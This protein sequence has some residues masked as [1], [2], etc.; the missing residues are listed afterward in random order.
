MVSL[1]PSKPVDQFAAQHTGTYPLNEITQ[2]VIQVGEQITEEIPLYVHA[3]RG[4]DAVA[5]VDGGL[6]QSAAAIDALLGEATRTAPL[7]YLCNTHPHHDHIGN[8]RRL[9]ERTGAIV[10]AAE[11]AR[12]WLADPERNIREFAF[13]HPHIFED[14]GKARAELA[15]TFD[16]VVTVDVL[17]Q[18]SVVLNLGGG[19]ELEAV[20][21]DGHLHAELAWFERSSRCLILGDAVTAIDW[22]IFHGH[23]DPVALRQTIRRLRHLVLDRDVVRIVFAHYE[24]RDRNGFLRLLI[25]LENYLDRVDAWVLDQT[26][27]QPRTLEEIW[28]GVCREARKEPE[29][30]SLA[31]VASHLGDQQLRGLVTLTA[32]ETYIRTNKMRGSDRE[33]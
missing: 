12:P 17:V 14:T 30:R 2:S 15:P 18:E 8:F 27:P 16:G 29:F 33:N 24:A 11:G 4:A 9:R 32:P 20:R 6:P 19:V 13:H 5:L 3:V 23:V 21:A 22:P 28:R 26:G 31:M 7:R 10:V 25:D 1:P